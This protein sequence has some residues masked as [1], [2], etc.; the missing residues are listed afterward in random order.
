M[1]A[2]LTETRSPHAGAAHGPGVTASTPIFG[3]AERGGRGGGGGDRGGPM[4]ID[5]R[6]K[7]Q[8]ADAPVPLS[9]VLALFRP[10]RG[11]VAVVVAIVLVIRELAG[12]HEDAVSG[13]GTAAWFG[14]IGG[15]VGVGG[16]ALLTGRR[17]GRA[18]AVV[19]QILLLPIAYALLTDSH[20]PW[21]GVPLALCALVILVLIFSPASTRWLAGDYEPEAPGG[22]SPR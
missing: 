9:R 8:L 11:R 2:T 18:I 22:D 14:I 15:G 4:T 7:A 13:F 6:D 20:Q 19:A 10:H 17:W 5:P 3:R 16:L 12:H 21:F 1:T